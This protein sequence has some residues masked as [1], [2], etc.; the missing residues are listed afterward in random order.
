MK[1]RKIIFLVLLAVGLVTFGLGGFY[2][3]YRVYDNDAEK[4]KLIGELEITELFS[5]ESIIVGEHG[6]LIDM[7]A[8]SVC[9]A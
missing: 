3:E 5:K 2:S 6:N 4:D 7:G 9:A 1:K 8:D